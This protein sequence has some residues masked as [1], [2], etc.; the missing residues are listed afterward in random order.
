M[1]YGLENWNAVRIDAE[2]AQVDEWAKHW[3]VAVI[4]T[5]FGVYRKYAA[6]KDRAAWIGDVRKALDTHGIGWPMWDYS[7][8]FG[9][10]T[11]ENDDSK[12]DEAILRAL[13]RTR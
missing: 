3:N 2:I 4:C 12:P 10:I 7:S 13:G 5:E 11:R 6:P 9:L 8:S 1:R